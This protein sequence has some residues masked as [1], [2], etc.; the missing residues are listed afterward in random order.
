MTPERL[1]ENA[2]TR[3]YSAIALTDHN[4]VSGCQEAETLGKARGLVVI[5]G[6]EYTTF[7]GHIVGLFDGIPFDWRLLTRENID[8]YARYAK[9]SGALLTI[10]HPMRV[11]TPVCTGCKMEFGINNYEYFTAFEVWSQRED[12]DS[13]TNIRAV[14]LYDSLLSRGYK[15]AAVYGYDWH[16]DEMSFDAFINTYIGAGKLS[17]EALKRGIRSGD[18]YL[19]SGIKLELLLDGK[20]TAFGSTIPGGVRG[21]GL[22]IEKGLA[23]ASAKPLKWIVKGS[24]VGS[25]NGIEAPVGESLEADLKPGWARFEVKG[26]LNERSATLAFTSPIYII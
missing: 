20:K 11:G 5:R 18:T 26:Y 12:S 7:Y 2:V 6:M 4:T 25:D 14:A 22:K 1:I 15:L 13:P 21:L 9:E 3:G 23:K 17:A 19:A 24:A 10:A 16:R 8:E